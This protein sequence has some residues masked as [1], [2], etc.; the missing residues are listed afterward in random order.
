MTNLMITVG[1]VIAMQYIHSEGIIYRD[2]KPSN[3]LLDWDWTVRIADFG[4][5]VWI[6][7]SDTGDQSLPMDSR[8]VPPEWYE[9]EWSFASD[10]FSFGLILYE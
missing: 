10:V 9:G 1:I 8:Y 6:G 3:I 2:L 7:D 4:C 5:S